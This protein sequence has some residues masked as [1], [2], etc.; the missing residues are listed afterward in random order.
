[1]LLIASE[2]RDKGGSG[3][4]DS[5]DVTLQKIGQVKTTVAFFG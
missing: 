1:M 5:G 4:G 3:F 2:I